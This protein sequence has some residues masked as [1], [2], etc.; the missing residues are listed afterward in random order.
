MGKMICQ[1]VIN[2]PEPSTFAASITSS[3]TDCNPANST[4]MTKGVHSQATIKVT[5][6][7]GYEENQGT[8]GRPTLRKTQST[9]PKLGLSIRF[10]QFSAITDG[11][12]RNG[13]VTSPRNT[14]LPQIG[15]FK[16]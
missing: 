15:R 2:G 12:T 14:F 4:S 9:I 5:L 3:G 7:S 1:N 6:S 8:A 13:M 10:F 11:V 16:S